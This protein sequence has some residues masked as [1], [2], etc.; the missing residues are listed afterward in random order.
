MA[1]AAASEANDVEPPNAIRK[2][3][4]AAMLR[5]AVDSR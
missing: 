4:H 3:I 2:L 1:V 5:C